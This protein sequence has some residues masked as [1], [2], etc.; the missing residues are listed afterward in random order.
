MR[1]IVI[2]CNASL[3]VDLSAAF[4]ACGI[5]SAACK[6][7]TA[8]KEL[9]ALKIMHH[10]TH[11]FIACAQKFAEKYGLVLQ[12]RRDDLNGKADPVD[13]TEKNIMEVLAANRGNLRLFMFREEQ[14]GLNS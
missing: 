3:R 6:V 13:V 12:A 11:D 10:Q 4:T 8:Q 5:P 1:P 14:K 2:L 9:N 7:R